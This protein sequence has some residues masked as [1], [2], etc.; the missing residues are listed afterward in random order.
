MER[1]QSLLKTYNQSHSEDNLLA[2]WN[3]QY[4][5]DVFPKYW[6]TTYAILQS[7][8]KNSRVIEIGCGLGAITSIL[9][10]LGY[11]NITSFEKVCYLGYRNITSFEKDSLLADKAKQ[12]IKDLFNRDNI[13]F[14]SEYPNGNAYSCDILILVNCAYAYQTNNKSEYLDSL[15]SFYES[16]GNPQYFIL[17]VID[18]S[19]TIDDDEFPLHIR[20][21][22]TDIR[23][24]FPKCA[25]KSW[26]TYKYP[27]NKK[28]KTLYLIERS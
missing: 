28:S 6:E 3:Q 8:N 21:N 5:Q 10:Y 13:I 2:P 7:L 14:T 19:Y 25:I 23:D 16:A 18:D 22:S 17:E 1:L 26:I 24:S 27:E 9:C 15:R 20:L 12:R 11:R 4:C